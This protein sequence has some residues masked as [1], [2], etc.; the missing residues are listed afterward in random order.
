VA[1]TRTDEQR[2]AGASGIA[3][4]A[5]QLADVARLLGL[6]V[7]LI[8]RQ[9]WMLRAIND[10]LVE[11]ALVNA[12][13]VAWFF[14]KS[15]DVHMSWFI[16][17]WQDG[18]V[19]IAGAAVGPISRYLGHESARADQM[20]SSIR[21]LGRSW[22]SRWSWSG[23]SSDLLTQSATVVVLAGFHQLRRIPTRRSRRRA[24]Y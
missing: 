8:A 6:Q 14:T 10:A 20:V 5:A 3:Y 2:A 11:S 16:G 23:A 17:D 19:D 24:S 18:I 7:P 15:S 12:R 4:R 21:A 22:N 9:D 13:A 1:S